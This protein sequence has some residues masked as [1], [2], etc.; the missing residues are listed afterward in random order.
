M[1]DSRENI[2]NVEVTKT[3]AVIEDQ[4]KVICEHLQRGV[5]AYGD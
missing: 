3:N 2:F 1:E 5:C 4:K